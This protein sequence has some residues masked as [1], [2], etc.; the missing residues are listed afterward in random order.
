MFVHV[1]SCV[2][3]FLLLAVCCAQP[4]QGDPAA[5]RRPQGGVVKVFVVAGQSNAV[6]YNHIREYR[7]GKIP[8]P[9][10]LL[11]QPGILYWLGK[12][13][14]KKTDESRRSLERD[15]RGSGETCER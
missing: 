13:E 11:K 14:T 7:R 6:G 1:R 2:V 5:S 8:F 10:E 15:S 9:P 12:A 4:A 3:S